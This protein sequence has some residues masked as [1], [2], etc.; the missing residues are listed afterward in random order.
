MK[1][2]KPGEK[3]IQ[4]FSGNAMSKFSFCL[5]FQ[6]TYGYPQGL[7]FFFSLGDLSPAP[8]QDKVKDEGKSPTKLPGA[9]GE[10]AAG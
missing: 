4:L 5:T 10:G 6:E 8:A 7:T 3:K 1:K 2:K 9:W